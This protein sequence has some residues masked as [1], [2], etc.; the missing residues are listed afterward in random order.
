MRHLYFPADIFQQSTAASVREFAQGRDSL[1]TARYL[2]NED[3]ATVG[4]LPLDRS[5][6]EAVPKI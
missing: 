4:E 6:P 1:L 2:G 3:G 5:D